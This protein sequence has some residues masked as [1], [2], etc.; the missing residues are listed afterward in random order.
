MSRPRPAAAC[1]CGAWI[2]TSTPARAGRP[3]AAGRR[4][5]PVKGRIW[6]MC[7][8]RRSGSLTGCICPIT[9]PRGICWWEV[10]RRTPL[11]I[12]SIPSAGWDCRRISEPCWWRA[13]RSILRT[14]NICSCPSRLWKK[15]RPGFREWRRS[16]PPAEKPSGWRR[17]CVRLP[18]TPWML[19]ECPRM[20]RILPCGSWR[21]PGKAT[22]STLPRRQWCCSGRRGWRPGM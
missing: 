8:W 19:R 12:P 21:R 14:P 22:A 9:P 5:L 4:P 20:R 10:R 18:S 6:G 11:C 16:R 13:L 2:M 1:T 17:W 3:P 15:L 7:P